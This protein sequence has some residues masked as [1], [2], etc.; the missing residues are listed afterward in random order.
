M[1]DIVCSKLSSIISNGAELCALSGFEVSDIAINCYDGVKSKF[2]APPSLDEWESP[3]M[4]LR[5]L[6]RRSGWLHPTVSVLMERTAEMAAWQQCLAVGGMAY[7]MYLLIS[8][9]IGLC[10]KAIGVDRGGGEVETSDVVGDGV[11]DEEFV[12]DQ[13]MKALA[14]Q[15]MIENSRNLESELAK[16]LGLDRMSPPTDDDGADADET[17]GTE[18]D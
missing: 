18:L 3:L 16:Q 1:G 2:V 15:A 11:V 4:R 13:R 12:R 10:L 5:T 9:L 14:R 6:L 7:S 8:Y 17:Q